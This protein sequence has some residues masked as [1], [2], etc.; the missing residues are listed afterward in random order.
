LAKAT[1]LTLVCHGATSATRTGAFPLD[2]PLES[3]EVLRVK[4]IAANL[5]HA[6]RLVTSPALRARQ[7]ADALQLEAAVDTAIADMDYGQWAGRLLA[8]IHAATPDDVERWMSD[9]DSAPHGG[10][11]FNDLLRRVARWLTTHMDDGGHTI[12]V[13]HALVIRAAIVHVLQAPVSAFWRID[14]EPLSCTE[15][16]S[17]GRRWILRTCANPSPRVT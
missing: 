10:E 14:V 13:T 7:T 3:G 5:R 6:H 2:E 12:A 17:D 15:M 9:A 4:G 11:S 8:D 16:S 1:R